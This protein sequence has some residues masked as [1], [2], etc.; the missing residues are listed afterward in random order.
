MSTIDTEI[1]LL[2]SMISKDLI[3]RR[4]AMTPNEMAAVTRQ[5]MVGVAIP[6]MLMAIQWPSV[7]GVLFVLFS[8][9][10][11]LFPIIGISLFCSVPRWIAFASVMAGALAIGP[12]FTLTDQEIAPLVVMLVSAV[13]AAPAV[14][15]R[16]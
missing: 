2:A 1:F 3:A 10:T 8:L 4:R 15:R 13:V 5:A 11:P 6:A 7:L 12:A 16:S 9:Q 14:F